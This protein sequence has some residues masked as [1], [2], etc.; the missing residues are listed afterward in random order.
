[1]KNPIKIFLFLVY[2][3]FSNNAFCFN[4][5]SIHEFEIFRNSKKIGFHKLSFQNI[6]DKIVVNTEIQMI[7]KLVGVIPVF[8]YFHKGREIWINNHFVEANTSTKKNRREFKFIA[9]KKGSKIEI[10]SRNK[11]FL[12]DGDSL[13]TSYWNQNWLK[14]KV[15]FDN[16]HGKKRLINVEKKNFE[17]IKTS[18]N[19]IFAQRYKVTGTQDKPNGKK[20]DYDIWYDDKGR[21]VKTKFF[22]KNSLI[23]YF[24]VTEY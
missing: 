5:K 11:V 23:E 16:Q 13:F 12:I 4:Y 10:K 21:W 15:L 14:K 17:K 18:N 7:D 8:K 9:K 20:I 19:T 24:L 1:M 6:E 2:L 22:L 3:F